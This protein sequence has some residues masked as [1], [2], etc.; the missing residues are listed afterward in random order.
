MTTQ[1]ATVA[2]PTTTAA[3]RYSEQIHALVDR[4]TREYTLGLAILAAEV[5]GYSRPKEGEQ[6]RDLLDAAIARA[7]KADPVAYEAAVRRGRRELAERAAEAEERA[8]KTSASVEAATA[9]RA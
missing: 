5:G 3:R 4:Q 6:I 8:A 9:T 7:Y 2:P 1:H